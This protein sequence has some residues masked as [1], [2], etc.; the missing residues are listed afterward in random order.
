MVI[1]VMNKEYYCLESKDPKRILP[2]ADPLNRNELSVM[3]TKA[4]LFPEPYKS[5]IKKTD[6]QCRKKKPALDVD[7]TGVSTLPLPQIYRHLLTPYALAAGTL[8]RAMQH[9][10]L[11]LNTTLGLWMHV[12]A[13]ENSMARFK[14]PAARAYGVRRWR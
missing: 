13:L 4:P 2:C 8:N 10:L 6:E 9:L 1:G 3:L 5:S 7:D 12:V 14:V 11:H